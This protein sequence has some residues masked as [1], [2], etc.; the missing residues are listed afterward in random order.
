MCLITWKIQTTVGSSCPERL[1]QR[2]RL[3]RPWVLGQGSAQEHPRQ[4]PDITGGKQGPRGRNVC[5]SEHK[6]S[7]VRRRNYCCGSNSV[8]SGGRFRND[9][10]R[11]RWPSTSQSQQRGPSAEKEKA[12]D[13]VARRVWFLSCSDT[14]CVSSTTP[15]EARF[16]ICETE[17]ASTPHPTGLK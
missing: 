1:E 2:P 6:Y 4:H 5:P 15:S 16:L 14:V 11:T 12:G 13:I 8:T 17:T 3:R 7:D 9:K 10:L